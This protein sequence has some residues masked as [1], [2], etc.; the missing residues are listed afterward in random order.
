MADL[1]KDVH[2][3]DEDPVAP[4]DIAAA[5][6]AGPFRYD[7]GASQIFEPTGSTTYTEQGRASLGEWSVD[8]NGRFCSFWRPPSYRACYDLRWVVENGAVVGLT[9][10]KSSAGITFRR[11]LPV[12]LERHAISRS[13]AGRRGSAACRPAVAG[14]PP[15]RRRGRPSSS[16]RPGRG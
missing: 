14:R 1:L 2:A 7:D 8:D 9:F 11:A 6:T 16:P 12:A 15:V 13:S 3:V 4:E 5:V 10:I